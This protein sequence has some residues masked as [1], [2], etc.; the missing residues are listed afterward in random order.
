M[1]AAIP[2]AGP[3]TLKGLQSANTVVLAGNRK[4]NIGVK[5]GTVDTPVVPATIASLSYPSGASAIA[6]SATVLTENKDKT[7]V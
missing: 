5:P 2:L 1:V 6:G 7:V 3:G 4:L